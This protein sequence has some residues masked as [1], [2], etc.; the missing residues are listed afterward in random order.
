MN[1]DVNWED[2]KGKASPGGVIVSSLL[3]CGAPLP[4]ITVKGEHILATAGNY[5][6]LSGQK[7]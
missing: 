3:P 4:I 2:N 7:G 6:A 5:E 1:N